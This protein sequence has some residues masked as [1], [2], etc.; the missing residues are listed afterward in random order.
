M[1]LDNR[2]F[3]CELDNDDERDSFGVCADPY[4]SDKMTFQT[5]FSA[6]IG[7]GHG[8]DDASFKLLVQTRCPVYEQEHTM[9][10]PLDLANMLEAHAKDIRRIFSSDIEWTQE[11]F[12]EIG[13]QADIGLYIAMGMEPSEA[14]SR[15]EAD[16]EADGE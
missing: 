5:E 2:M 13:K 7:G 8:Q 4:G 11:N 1:G 3:S 10:T 12:K 14:K 9:V 6:L 15:Q 16:Q